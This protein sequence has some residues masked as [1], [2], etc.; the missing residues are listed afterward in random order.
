MKSGDGDVIVDE[1]AERVRTIAAMSNAELLASLGVE[2][3]SRAP[4]KVRRF[5]V[6]ERDPR[7]LLPAL[8]RV[9]HA[10]PSVEV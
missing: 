1:D 3:K 5:K 8:H 9:G 6:G 10:R 4:L 2:Q 7:E